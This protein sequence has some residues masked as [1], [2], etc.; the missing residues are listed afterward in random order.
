MP[1]LKN[2]RAAE[3]E[4]H[5][6]AKNIFS[7]LQGES[8]KE[9][10][11]DNL[12]GIMELGTDGGMFMVKYPTSKLASSFFEWASDGAIPHLMKIAFEKYYMWK[13]S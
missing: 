9:E 4:G 7:Q 11:H 1:M 10:F 13:L 3:L 8:P 2:G 12:L 5:I 6:A